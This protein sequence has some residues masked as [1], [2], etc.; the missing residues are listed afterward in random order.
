MAII[1]A[2]LPTTGGVA[3]TFA[4][5]TA[6]VGGDEYVNTGK[7]MLVVNNA[8]GAP[9]TVTFKAKK[10]CN[11]GTLHDVVGS[12]AAGAIE[13]FSPVDGTFYNDPDTGRVQ[14]TY[15]AVTSVTVAVLAPTS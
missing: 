1:A 4:A 15:S 8:S 9:I 13:Y 11:L 6:G 14:V 2:Q 12:V 10:A 5:A 7:Q 3:L